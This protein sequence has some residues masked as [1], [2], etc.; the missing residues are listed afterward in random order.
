MQTGL[1]FLRKNSRNPGFS[2]EF[3]ADHKNGAEAGPEYGEEQLNTG[4]FQQK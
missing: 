4:I 3:G 1:Y 2:T